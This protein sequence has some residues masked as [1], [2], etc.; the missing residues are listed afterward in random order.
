MNLIQTLE[1]EEIARLG[2]TIP[3]YDAVDCG[4]F[5]ATPELASA[6]RAAIDEGKA[7]S[8]SEG[9]QKLADEYRQAAYFLREMEIANISLTKDELRTFVVELKTAEE[10]QIN[11]PQMG[12]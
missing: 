8:L 1:A 10:Q 5:L 7:G 9:M 4:A 12:M 2:K 6:I 3:E 11:T